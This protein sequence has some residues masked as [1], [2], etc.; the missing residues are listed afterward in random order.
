MKKNIGKIAK[1]GLKVIA[2]TTEV[3]GK[4][5]G[6]VPGLKPLGKVAEGVAKVTDFASDKIPGGNLGGSLEKGMDVMNKAEEIMGYI[7]RDLSEEEDFHWQRE[8]DYLEDRDNY[9]R[10]FDDYLDDWE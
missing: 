5:A 10:G 4:V 6:F 2:T 8:T 3:I 9:E 7:P 1:F